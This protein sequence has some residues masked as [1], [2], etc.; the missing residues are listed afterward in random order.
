MV[1]VSELLV[2]N[3]YEL[4]VESRLESRL[5]ANAVS[6]DLSSLTGC[7]KRPENAFYGAAANKSCNQR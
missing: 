3:P 5:V 4:T 1:R 7:L 2:L 6:I